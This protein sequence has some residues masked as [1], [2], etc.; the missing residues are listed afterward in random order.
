MDETRREALGRFLRAR[1]EALTPEKAGISSRR[2]RR[3]PGLRR[4]EVAFLADIGVKWYARLEA[5]D[6]VNP[7]SATLSGIARALQLTAA[8]V[9]YVLD[10]AQVRE[11]Q[12]SSDEM[13]TIVPP[14]YDVLL[15]RMRGV[16][17]MVGDRIL[18]P[19][20]WNALADAVYGYSRI[21]N[22]IDRNAIVRGLFDQEFIAF[23]GPD[24]EE[25]ARKGVGMLRLNHSSESRSPLASAVYERV[26]DHPLFAKYWTERMVAGELT[27]A[28]PMIRIHPVV[29]R[30]A[31]YALDFSSWARSDLYLRTV[32]PADDE[33]AA[34]FAE[35]ERDTTLTTREAS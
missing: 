9:E 34:K 32:Y 26:K 35:L 24:Y 31:L 8:E 16:A 18:T 20:R 27:D 12:R 21:P 15:S 13:A 5:G 23:L 29:G 2:G 4:E 19:L 25:L 1:R 33:T 28:A 17:G 7:S 6:E 30:L 22:P 3:T 14:I 10:L 11:P